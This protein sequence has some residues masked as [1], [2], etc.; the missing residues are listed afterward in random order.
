MQ[1]QKLIF[2]SSRVIYAMHA[3][4]MYNSRHHICCSKVHMINYTH[5]SAI[6][7]TSEDTLPITVHFHLNYFL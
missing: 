1:S 5:H 7:I 3:Y 4:E 6:P 2:F